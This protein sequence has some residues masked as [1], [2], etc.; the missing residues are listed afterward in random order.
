[1]GFAGFE[2]TWDG[3]VWSMAISLGLRMHVIGFMCLHR[4]HDLLERGVM[5]YC[6]I[7]GIMM[8]FCFL[9]ERVCMFRFYLHAY[10]ESSCPDFH[11]P[12]ERIQR[13]FNGCVL[14]SRLV[15]WHNGFRAV[16]SHCSWFF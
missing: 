2:L 14:F 15:M 3:L 7:L 10:L 11:E 12:D 4:G 6:L 5:V 1:M 8:D 13:C 9:I 16:V